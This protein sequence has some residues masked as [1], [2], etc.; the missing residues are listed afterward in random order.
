MKGEA[1]LPPIFKALAPLP[2]VISLTAPEYDSIGALYST[3][4]PPFKGDYVFDLKLSAKIILGQQITLICDFCLIRG[5]AVISKCP[6][7]S[8]IDLNLQF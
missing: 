8:L 7:D 6:L 2:M 1:G 5:I 3:L 4:S